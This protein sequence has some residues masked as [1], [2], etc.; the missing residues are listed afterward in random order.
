MPVEER[1]KTRVDVAYAMEQSRQACEILQR[2]SGATSSYRSNPI[3]RSFR[4]I[5]VITNHAYFNY[6]SNMTLFGRTVVGLE[7]DSPFI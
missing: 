4:D 6:D 1:L 3:Q 7:P 5:Q 2:I